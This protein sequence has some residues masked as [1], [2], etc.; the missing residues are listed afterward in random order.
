MIQRDPAIEG[1]RAAERLSYLGWAA[2]GVVLPLLAPAWAIFARPRLPGSVEETS[3]T[4]NVDH[5]TFEAHFARTAKR[6]RARYAW[7]GTWIGIVL[8]AGA[9]GMTLVNELSTWLAQ[10]GPPATETA[11]PPPA[12]AED[13]P[14]PAMTNLQTQHTAAT[15]P[16]RDDAT[17]G[18]SGGEPPPTPSLDGLSGTW[19]GTYV[20]EAAD[21]SEPM[22]ILFGDSIT[23]HYH[24]SRCGGVLQPVVAS[25]A[26]SPPA[27]E[28]STEY[29]ESLTFGQTRCAN[30]ATVKLLRLDDE[31]LSFEWHPP[32][33][34]ASGRGRA[35]LRRRP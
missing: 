19:T 28:G 5:E 4:G 1:A 3:P 13:P 31:T 32:S 24:G 35:T 11:A 14:E 9:A 18:A 6:S 25:F 22:T 12:R 27:P 34:A 20:A 33:T 10:S 21:G 26:E 7:I 2:L 29:V 30:R 17:P 16:D 15:E 23:I 8:H